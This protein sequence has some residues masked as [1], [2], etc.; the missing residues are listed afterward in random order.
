MAAAEKTVDEFIAYRLERIVVVVV[1]LAVLM[2][3]AKETADGT[4]ST[5]GEEECD[6]N[7]EQYC[8]EGVVDKACCPAGM[9]CNF[10]MTMKI[11]KDGSCVNMPDECEDK[12]E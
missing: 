8:N 10:G 7:W 4:D 2:A 12:G 5:D 11:C 1:L 3:T 9:A 6:G